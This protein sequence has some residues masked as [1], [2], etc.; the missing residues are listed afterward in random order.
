M[1]MLVAEAG[2]GGESP[3]GGRCFEVEGLCICGLC[4]CEVRCALLS[5]AGDGMDGSFFSSA[6]HWPT[7]GA[8]SSTTS[9]D[10]LPPTTNHHNSIDSR[11]D[12]VC[13]TRIR[14]VPP[15]P[16]SGP[17]H[18][19]DE[20]AEPSIEH[21]THPSAHEAYAGKDRPKLDTSSLS[22]TAE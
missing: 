10:F 8:S 7:L 6:A 4:R 12:N 20:H 1:K 17:A 3:G 13:T 5:S 16:G 19:H 15:W 22:L 14:H 21:A 9:S 18:P 11:L 2:Q